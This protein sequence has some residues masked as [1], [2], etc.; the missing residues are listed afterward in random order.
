MVVGAGIFVLHQV[1][2]VRVVRSSFDGNLRR[3]IISGRRGL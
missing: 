1:V 3:D 2:F